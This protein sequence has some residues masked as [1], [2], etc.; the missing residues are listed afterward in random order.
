MQKK[1]EKAAPEAVQVVEETQNHAGEEKYI[2]LNR[3][4]EEEGTGGLWRG[5]WEGGNIWNVNK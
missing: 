5:N 3:Q 1:R 4:E 2:V